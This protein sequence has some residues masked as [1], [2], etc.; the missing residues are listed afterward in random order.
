MITK[1]EGFYS[2]NGSPVVV[3][4]GLQVSFSESKQFIEYATESDF[5]EA[6]PDYGVAPIEEEPA[7]DEPEY[8]FEGGL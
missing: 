1:N 5:M 2:L 7:Y 3:D 8:L 6:F 4:T